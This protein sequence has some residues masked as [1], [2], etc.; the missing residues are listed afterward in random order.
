MKSS[1][2]RTLI[3]V[4]PLA[5]AALAG[6]LWVQRA[7]LPFRAN[8]VIYLMNARRYPEALEACES[9]QR[10]HPQEARRL[11]A[12]FRGRLI[13]HAAAYY[14]QPYKKRLEGDAYRAFLDAVA[15]R[16]ELAPLARRKRLDFMALLDPRS[17]ATLSAARDIL[18][19]E[20]YDAEAFWWAAAGQYNPARPFSI[21]PELAR[22]RRAFEADAAARGARGAGEAAARITFLNTL[23]ALADRNWAQAAA[24]F[25]DYRRAHPELETFDLIQAIAT[26]KSGRAEA[27]IHPLRQFRQR[28]PADPSTLRYLADA[29]LALGDYPWASHMLHEIR[30][31]AAD[32]EILVFQDTF[33]VRGDAPL[34]Q[35]CAMLRR[36]G[37]CEGDVALWAWLDEMA[38]TDAQRRDVAAAADALI[39]AGGLGAREQAALMQGALWR[40]HAGVAARLC[41]AG[42]DAD[43]TSTLRREALARLARWYPGRTS[44]AP[45]AATSATLPL[46]NRDMTAP[47]RLPAPRGAT[48]LVVIAQGIPAR[49]VWPIVHVDLEQYGA[50]SWYLGDSQA[51][52]RP[53][54]MAL[55]RPATGEP[56]EGSI[57]L[58]NGGG[59]GGGADS[60]P[61]MRG[62]TIVEVKA[63]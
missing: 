29:Y 45:G 59:S 32:Q 57:A 22:Y 62:V 58:I 53:I 46:M 33:A 63:F 20:G 18:A 23:L 12:D 60:G 61:E 16:P 48:L 19:R 47:L 39:A 38:R 28:H 41:A 40:G 49:G 36:G 21:P 14:S 7:G 34:S 9:L 17:S 43:A 35:T 31:Q 8:R 52:A 24:G 30:A 51:Q 6:A 11:P 54:V 50:Q 13:E 26:L 25:E 37:A 27:A 10:N 2:Q 1:W 44:A 15:R 56:I 55:R 5:L 42:A 3:V 4:A